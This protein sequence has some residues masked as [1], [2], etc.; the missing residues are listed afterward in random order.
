MSPKKRRLWYVTLIVLFVGGAALIILTT[1]TDHLLF[2]MTPTDVLEKK[3]TTPIRLGGLV[4][5]GSLQ[6]H[7][8]TLRMTFRVT[9]GQNAISV[10]YQG[11]IPDLF[12]ERQGV[13]AEGTLSQDGGFQATRLL[14][15]HDET[16]MP[17]EVAD[18][19]K[20]NDQRR[21]REALS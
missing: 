10:Q 1:L 9:D 19:L 4:E 2:F 16:Y 11:I 12:R 17:R 6:R 7:K 3:P 13:V 18:A 8:E 20:A 21:S 14:A 15:K 5:M